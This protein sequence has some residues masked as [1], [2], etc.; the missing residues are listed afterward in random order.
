[1]SLGK[2]GVVCYIYVDC[3]SLSRKLHGK[4]S[5]GR[6]INELSD[7]VNFTDIYI[8]LDIAKRC[9]YETVRLSIMDLILQFP[10]LSFMI[11]SAVWVIRLGLNPLFELDDSLR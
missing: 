4:T 6:S 2:I 5:G 3:S 9:P 10:N 11:S 7:A 8:P 1:M